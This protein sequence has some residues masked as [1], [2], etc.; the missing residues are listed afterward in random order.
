MQIL[1]AVAIALLGF[2]LAAPEVSAFDAA[3]VFGARPSAADVSLSPDGNSVAYVV[4]TEGMGSVLYTVRLE[5]GA[6]PKV[7]LV[8]SGKPELLAGCDWVSNDRLVCTVYGILRDPSIT[9]V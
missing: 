5:E 2:I 9:L 7:A 1:V 6:K 4:P 3:V 8:A